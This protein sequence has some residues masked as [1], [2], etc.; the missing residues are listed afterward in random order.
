MRESTF[1]YMNCTSIMFTSPHIQRRQQS[2]D[3]KHM[4]S[5]TASV[6]VCVLVWKS[7]NL[8]S[9]VVFPLIL[10]STSIYCVHSCIYILEFELTEY[11]MSNSVREWRSILSRSI[12]LILRFDNNKKKCPEGHKLG[13]QPD[14]KDFR[15]KFLISISSA[16]SYPQTHFPPILPWTKEMQNL[17]AHNSNEPHKKCSNSGWK[18]NH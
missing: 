2:D 18:I 4:Y 8:I 10:Y 7:M 15:I 12:A 11:W 13:R 9:Y 14:W 1:V 5:H 17:M 16:I 3:Y 6:C